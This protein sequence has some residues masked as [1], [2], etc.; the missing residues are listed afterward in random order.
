MFMT[1]IV[2]SILN[3]NNML[4]QK[5]KISNNVMRSCRIT[6]HMGIHADAV[7]CNISSHIRKM[8]K[9]LPKGCNTLNES[10]HFKG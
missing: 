3:G 7:F 2:K 1:Y 9:S 4:H 10:T 8:R 6:I 5:K